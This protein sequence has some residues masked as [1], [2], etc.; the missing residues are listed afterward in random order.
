[1]REQLRRHEHLYYVLDAP[2][3]TDAEYDAMLRELK[4]LEDAHPELI[5]ADSPKQLTRDSGLTTE[6]AIQFYAG[7]F[8]DGSITGKGGAVYRKRHALC[9]EC[10]H[11]P[12]SPNKPQFPTTVLKPG[13]RYT[14]TTVYRFSAK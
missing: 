11:F 4:N 10:Q 12:D 6:P 8:L 1:L 3:V 9:L 7:N 2:E 14:Q 5:T 13:E